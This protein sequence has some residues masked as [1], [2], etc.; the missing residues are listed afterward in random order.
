[1]VFLPNYNVVR[2]CDII[3]AVDL[4]EQMSTAQKEESSTGNMKLAMNGAWIIRTL[5]S[6]KV[7]IKEEIRDTNLFVF[8]HTETELD[9]LRAVDISHTI[10]A[11]RIK[12]S[13]PFSTG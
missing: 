6:A 10:I 13:V 2:A 9:K 3:P 5:D 11:L 7:E 4:S 1:V 12:C 8:G